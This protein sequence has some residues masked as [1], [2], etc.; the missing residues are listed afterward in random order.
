MERIAQGRSATLTHTFYVDGVATNPS[1]DTATVAITR[2]DGTA[3]V[4]AGAVTD[5]GTGVVTLTLT[6]TETALLDT[7]K[8]TW[9]A[10]FGGQ[11]QGFTDYVEVAGGFLFSLSQA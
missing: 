8:V 5:A 4:P 7:L 6:P 1:P 10:S 11:S 2:A 9:T 3:L